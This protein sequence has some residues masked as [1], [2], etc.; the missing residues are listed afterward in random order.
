MKS[1]LNGVRNAWW[2]ASDIFKCVNVYP[3]EVVSSLGYE[4]RLFPC[5][6]YFEWS[7]HAAQKDRSV[8]PGSAKE[9]QDTWD[10]AVSTLMSYRASCSR[11]GQMS[12]HFLHFTLK[13]SL[14][15]LILITSL[16]RMTVWVLHID[17][18]I[19]LFGLPSFHILSTLNSTAEFHLLKSV[20]LL[21]PISS[22]KPFKV[23]VVYLIKFRCPCYLFFISLPFPNSLH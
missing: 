23:Y 19:F 7:V 16:W 9:K 20:A 8:I 18:F 22:S 17:A 10:L 13:Y 6:G 3:L 2:C 5:L 14:T 12:E 11:F 21:L 1:V 4:L 15:L